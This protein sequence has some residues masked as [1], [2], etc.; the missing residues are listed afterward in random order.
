MIDPNPCKDC[1]DR[2]PACHDHCEGY[3]HWREQ[4]RAEQEHLK[5]E[6]GRWYVPYSPA[7]VEKEIHDIKHPLKG[8]KGGKQ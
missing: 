4:N 5:F 6:R 3:Q 1:T 8:R 2:H 7:R